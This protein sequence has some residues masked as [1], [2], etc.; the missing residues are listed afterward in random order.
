MEDKAG[1]GALAE[2]TRAWLLG[3][4]GGLTKHTTLGYNT[5]Y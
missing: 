5:Q 4:V 1:A 2:T 3:T